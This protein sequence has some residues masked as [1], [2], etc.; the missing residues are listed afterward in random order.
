MKVLQVN[1]YESPGKRFH[2]LTIAPLLKKYGIKSQ[3][4]VWE[5]DT[6]NNAVLTWSHKAKIRN[7]MIELIEK[8]GSLQSMLYENIDEMVSMP[9]FKE[10]DLVHLHIILGYLN[11]KDLIKITALKP[12]IWT[13]H[14]PWAMT[15]HCIHPFECTRWEIGC[16]ECPDLKIHMP[17]EFDT[18]KFLFNY[19]KN[20]YNNAN[21]N[22]L[23]ASNWMRNMVKKS[24]MFENVPTYLI[25][26]GVDL[27]FFSP[28]HTKAAREFFKIPET[29]IVIAFRSSE[30][31]FKGL[32]YIIEALSQ[33]KTDQKVWL[34]GIGNHGSSQIEIL[35]DRFKIIDI[36]WSDNENLT[37][38]VIAASDI[39][40]MP[41]LAEAFGMMAIEAMACEKTV[42]VFEGTALP[43]VVFSPD[44]G[45]A[46]P[47]CDSQALCESIE[48]LLNNPA[49][50]E[51]RGKDGRIRAQEYYDQNTYVERTAQL[52]KQIGNK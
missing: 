46:V 26:F 15:G 52:Y 24:P 35:A 11:I 43:D 29:D 12:T 41:S 31:R 45:I 36:G 16:G 50:R 28:V 39:F 33:L 3:H 32:S 44:V 38:N 47:M 18:T 5:K 51:R 34:V 27:E 30:S 7:Q 49:E 22:I 10:A 19:K 13:L 6:D 21:L 42:I 4:L 48:F 23:V 14:D 25:P 40:V 17:L 2:G 9:C 20:S 37:R 1:R 8:K